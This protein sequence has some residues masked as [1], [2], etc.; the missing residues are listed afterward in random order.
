MSRYGKWVGCF[1]L[2]GLEPLSRG[3]WKLSA[4]GILAKGGAHL[5]AFSPRPEIANLIPQPNL[6]GEQQRLW[7]LLWGTF[8]EP[9]GDHASGT[10][11]GLFQNPMIGP[12]L[13]ASPSPG[14]TLQSPTCLSGQEGGLC[15]LPPRWGVKAQRAGPFAYAL[16]QGTGC[17][18]QLEGEVRW[19]AALATQNGG[20]CKTEGRWGRGGRTTTCGG[21]ELLLGDQVSLPSNREVPGCA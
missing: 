7:A 13:F 5:R 19:K 21:R 10:K 16:L 8:P 15:F 1:G 3:V 11:K 2:G 12:L 6:P 20:G 17:L 9:Q 14:Q 18:S 4:Q